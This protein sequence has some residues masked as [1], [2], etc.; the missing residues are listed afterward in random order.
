MITPLIRR[1]ASTAIPA[2]SRVSGASTALP[3]G[4][5]AQLDPSVAFCAS[6]FSSRL[7]RLRGLYGLPE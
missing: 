1:D 5:C 6:R 3:S 2:L 4:A 7:R